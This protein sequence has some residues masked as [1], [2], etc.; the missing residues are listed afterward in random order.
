[1]IIGMHPVQ[2][3]AGLIVIIAI[4]I[5]AFAPNHWLLGYTKDEERELLDDG[6]DADEDVGKED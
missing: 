6:D 3:A 5:V 1:M 2:F 4:A